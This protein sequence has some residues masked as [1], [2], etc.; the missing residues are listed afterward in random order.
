MV[1]LLSN[2]GCNGLSEN[3]CDLVKESAKTSRVLDAE[4]WGG[5]KIMGNIEF[6]GAKT[7]PPLNLVWI[8]VSNMELFQSSREDL[9]GCTL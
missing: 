2:G 4:H 3:R 7:K 1:D 9:F 8:P 6:V 5:L